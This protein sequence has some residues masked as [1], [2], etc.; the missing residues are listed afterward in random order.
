[1]AYNSSN[2]QNGY[3]DPRS[4]NAYPNGSQYNDNPRQIVQ[5]QVPRLPFP[6]NLIQNNHLPYQSNQAVSYPSP[7][8]SSPQPQYAQYQVQAQH[9]DRPANVANGYQSQR[10]I[11]RPQVPPPAVEKEP[12]PI[13]YSLLLIDLAEEYFDAA[14]GNEAKG[15]TIR[16]EADHEIFCKRVA[17]GLGCLEIVLRVSY[18]DS[19]KNARFSCLSGV[20]AR[21]SRRSMCQIALRLSP[22]PGH[23]EFYRG[24]GNVKQRSK[25][26]TRIRQTTDL[27]SNRYPCVRG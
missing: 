16:R 10:H 25:A 12:P 8:S 11:E 2:G 13:D 5:V 20:E 4:G 17:T 26:P 9:H 7:Q 15:G 19:S 27:M 6:G 3:Y 22:I 14:Y 24:R 1:M 23:R 18:I 21:L